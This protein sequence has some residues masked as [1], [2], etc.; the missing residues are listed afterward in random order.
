MNPGNTIVQLQQRAKILI[1][2]EIKLEV[3]KL[4]FNMESIF[5]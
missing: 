5:R 4:Y 2:Y 1:N 3:L